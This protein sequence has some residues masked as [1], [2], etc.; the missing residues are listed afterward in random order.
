M[1]EPKSKEHEVKPLP[2]VV[3]HWTFTGLALAGFIN[4]VYLSFSHYRVYTDPAYESFCAISSAVNCDTV[5]QSSYSIFLGVPVPVWGVIGFTFLLLAVPFASIKAAEKK[6]MWSTLF[7]TLLAY[8]T[9]SVIL[10]AIST[11]VIHSYCIMCLLSFAITFMLLYFAWLI[12]RRFSRSGLVDS[13]LRDWRFLVQHKRLA[14]GFF[15]LFFTGLILTVVLFPVYWAFEPTTVTTS[16]PTGITEEGHPWIGAP[17]AEV[18]ITEYTDYL[19]FQCNKVHYYLRKMMTKYPG[20]L[21]VIHRHFPMDHR[22]NPL[23]KVPVHKGSGAL[24]LMAIYAQTRGKFWPMNDFLFGNARKMN[25]IDLNSLAA[26]LGLD[27]KGLAD[28]LS[29]RRIRNKLNR[30]IIDGLKLGVQGTPTFNIDGKT[31]RGQIPMEII[32]KIVN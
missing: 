21:K 3:Y 28:A 23:V 17:D 1:P 20:K 29:D 13:L 2:F 31:Y 5:S 4:A 25:K 26:T 22:V 27:Y 19:C 9:Y 8:S 10:A 11:F 12:R 24:S 7:V 30:D 32:S 14:A 18:V 6:R 16:V 15:G